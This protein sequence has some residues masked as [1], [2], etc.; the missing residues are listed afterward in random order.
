M[1]SWEK[2]SPGR[3]WE[4]VPRD[5]MGNLAF[6][7][8]MLEA[9]HGDK[10]WQNVLLEMCRKDVIFSIAVFNWQYNPN[11]IGKQDEFGPF[12]PWDFQI[13]AVREILSAIVDRKDLV[14]EKSR[15]MGASWLCLMVMEWL[16]RFHPRKKFLFISRDADAVDKTGEPDSLF[17]KIDFIHKNLPR[18][19]MPREWDPR[20]HRLNFRFIN[21]DNDSTITGQ[22]STSK[23]GVG[24]RA[25]AIF[26]DEF[27]KI[28]D[29]KKVR[30]GTASTSGCRIFNGTHEGIDKELYNL[31]QQPEV[32]KLV[33]HWTMH[34]EKCKGMYHYDEELRQLVVDDP[35]YD[36]DKDWQ[37][38]YNRDG[39]EKK[40]VPVIDGTPS[41]GYAPGIRSPWYDMQANKIGT[42]R[43]VAMELDIDARGSAFL[44][45][46]ALVIHRLVR[47]KAR[48]PDW[49]GD[50]VVVDGEIKEFLRRKGGP[51][52]MW[53]A[54]THMQQAPRQPYCAGADIAYGL[55]ATPSVFSLGAPDLGMKVLEFASAEIEETEFADLSVALCRHFC[56]AK[57][58]GA[59]LCWDASGAAG[60]R[61]G[62]RVMDL[63][64]WNI[65]FR[66]SEESVVRTPTDTPGWYGR[67]ETKNVLLKEYAAALQNGSLVNPSELALLET[68]SFQWKNSVMV[69]SG[70]VAADDP[71]KSGDNHGDRV[72]A[73]AL[74][75]KMMKEM[76]AGIEY[77]PWKKEQEDYKPGTLGWLMREDER[78]R[79]L[80]DADELIGVGW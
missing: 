24:G 37:K 14:I 10:H 16:W 7:R 77:R 29:D 34:P 68:L 35:S 78:T 4:Q 51:L 11:A 28:R 42:S 67:G 63:G 74:L 60:Q 32:R 47:E 55:Q 17:W 8:A 59:R 39:A 70:A 49:E 38:D 6:R 65:Y 61:Y 80:D 76:G 20:N 75:W 33:M 22:A 64:Y 13:D 1:K 72:I 58:H 21:P 26:I 66:A 73:D 79:R 27:S 15:E 62:R 18:W 48:E 43:A 54:L 30:Q 45:F 57:G 44:V 56:D 12:I 41:G 36:F 50:A 25:T 5:R 23:A 2:L 9:A 69:H 19:L 52:R 31:T 3:Y 40:F 71:A 53:G 46:D